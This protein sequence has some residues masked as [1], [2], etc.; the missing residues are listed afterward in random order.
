MVGFIASLIVSALMTGG[1]YWYGATRRKPGAGLSWGEA[2]LAATY[3]TINLFF[4]Y[5]I[6]PHQFLIWA[7]NELGWD[8][9]ALVAG[10]GSE[11][12]ADVLPFTITKLHIRDNIVV[13]LHVIPFSVHVW[14]VAWWNKR[15]Q[16]AAAKAKEIPTSTY[17]RPL[18]K[19]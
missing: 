3:V 19:G 18:V 17:G 13:M 15:E 1:I 7:E 6:M 12:L 10:P 11:A 2:F 8:S 14:M 5:G 4:W 9:G 16:K